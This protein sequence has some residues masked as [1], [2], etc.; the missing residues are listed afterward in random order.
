MNIKV[1]IKNITIDSCK[2]KMEYL[3]LC[4]LWN[5]HLHRKE[6]KMLKTTQKDVNIFSTCLVL[7]LDALWNYFFLEYSWDRQLPQNWNDAMY[8][9]G[10][11]WLSMS[12]CIVLANILNGIFIYLVDAVDKNNNLLTEFCDAFVVENILRWINGVQQANL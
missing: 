7:E 5:P 3:L 6:V 1:H 8:G 10:S 9:C 12:Q 2:T 4:V 11:L